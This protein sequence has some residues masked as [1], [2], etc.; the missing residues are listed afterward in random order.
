MVK[1]MKNG[2]AT[3][4][5][6]DIKNQK[7]I[8]IKWHDAHSDGGWRTWK[9]VV[10]LVNEDYCI[11]ENVGWLIFEDKRELLIA[12]RRLVWQEKNKETDEL[13]LFQKIPKPWIIERKFIK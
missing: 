12:S 6:I 2:V 5:P 8:Y 13:G 7:L 1:S 3:K 11:C 4:K 10:D 9:Q